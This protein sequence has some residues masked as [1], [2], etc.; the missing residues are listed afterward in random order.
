MPATDCPPVP[1]QF[2]Q[3][4][5]FLR[6]ESGEKAADARRYYGDRELFYGVKVKFEFGTEEEFKTIQKEEVDSDGTPVH[7][8][9]HLS[10]T[11]ASHSTPPTPTQTLEALIPRGQTFRPSR[12]DAGK[13]PTFRQR[14]PDGT[15]EGQCSCIFLG[16]VPFELLMDKR[17]I[18]KRFERFGEIRDIRIREYCCPPPEGSLMDK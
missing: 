10:E 6:F 2:G 15:Y 13:F 11:H 14:L 17:D 8:S 1:Q 16:N 12:D 7:A 9:S 3:R 18:W 5:V 4:D